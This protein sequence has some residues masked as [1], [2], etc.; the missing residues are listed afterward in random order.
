MQ[1]GQHDQKMHNLKK[2]Y[3]QLCLILKYLR[4][5]KLVYIEYI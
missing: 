5:G 2:L 1:Q 4:R 3:P